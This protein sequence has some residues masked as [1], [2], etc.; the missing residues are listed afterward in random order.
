[1]DNKRLGNILIAVSIFL[2]IGFVGIKNIDKISFKKHSK[3]PP[4]DIKEDYISDE[5]NHEEDIRYGVSS[6][7]PLA[8]EV[9]I[10]VLED[11]GNAV[12]AAVAMAFA[13]NVVDPQNSGIG[14]GGG[15]LIKNT[16]TGEKVFY[17]YYISSGDKEP[18]KNIGIPGFLRGMELINKE[19]GTK[20]L[21]DL[22]QYAID[23]GE[24]GIEITEDY[25]ENL[26]QR[27]YIAS[28]HPDFNK[29]GRVLEKG[30][31]LYQVELVKTL[32]EIQE[33]GA[34]IFYNGEHEISKNFLDITGISKESL[35]NYKVHK[36]EPL[37]IEYRGYNV[38]APPA[39]FSG[40]T[41]LQNL[42]IEEKIDIPQLDFGNKEY[43]KKI[44]N[45]FIFTG[46]ENRKTIGDPEFTDIDYNKKLD[47]DY[48]MSKYND[49]IKDDE[50]YEEPE[51][52]STTAYTVIDK[53]GLIVSVTNTLSNYWGSY[54]VSDGIVYNNA[55][56]NFTRGKNKFEY[57]K[58]PKT[59]IS[60]TI[61]TKGDSHKEALATSGGTKIPEY[62]FTYIVNT[63]KYGMDIQQAN[64]LERIYY[65]MGKMYFEIDAPYSQNPNGTIDFD[66]KYILLETSESWGI[67]SGIEIKSDNQIQ[68]H[69][70]KRGYFEGRTIY[71][72]GQEKL[73]H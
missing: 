28:V 9:G 70:D 42:L 21:A 65:L 66:D 48:L 62:L 25:A 53:D 71:F 13:L 68:G 55:M 8:T 41:L 27:S 29:D 26:Q 12:D 59:G 20:E 54:V 4:N 40:L 19:M 49:N 15:M 51:V 36:Y 47:I 5:N 64:D 16:S 18:R 34:E 31:I 39:P 32:K 63:K 44:Q 38:M 30:D 43:N 22:I 57:N 52:E 60:P 72:N 14:G 69:I 23:L 61:I 35:N 73:Y 33:H 11:G 2:I 58:R 7:N 3:T 50:D 6:I 10:K 24:T 17:D 56:K 37:E 1:M 67:M 46:R 45:L